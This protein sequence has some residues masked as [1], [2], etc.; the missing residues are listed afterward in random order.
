ML[1]MDPSLR[2]CVAQGLPIGR[3]VFASVLLRWEVGDLVCGI[4]G[5]KPHV[6]FVSITVDLKLEED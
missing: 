2:T 5:K 1:S 6:I 3:K 4:S